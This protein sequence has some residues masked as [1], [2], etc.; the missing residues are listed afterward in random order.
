M[1]KT[2]Q[3]AATAA[4]TPS[5]PASIGRGEGTGTPEPPSLSLSAH[6]MRINTSFCRRVSRLTNHQLAVVSERVLWNLEVERGG[7]FPDAARDVVVGSVAGAEPTAVV[8][9]LADGY[10]S[11]MCADACVTRGQ[12]SF[13]QT[14][15]S[16]SRRAPRICT[17]NI[18]SMTS[19]SGSLTRSSSVWGSRSDWTLTLLASSISAA[20]RWRTKTGLPRH[21]I[22]TCAS[23]SFPG[24]PLFLLI[25]WARGKS[26]RSCPRGSRR[27]QPRPWPEP[28]RRRKPTCS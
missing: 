1:P 17:A 19:H 20:V 24:Q 12:S 15:R 14:R 25:R 13:S 10:A 8:A 9:R 5:F 26:S 7:S 11:E 27:G 18:P 3:G 23:S 21:L 4:L 22:I 2:P 6:P 28:K 16:P